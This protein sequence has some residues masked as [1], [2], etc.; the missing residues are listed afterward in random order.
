MNLTTTQILKSILFQ[1]FEKQPSL[2]KHVKVDVA[3]EQ[4]TQDKLSSWQELWCILRRV[5]QD[6]NRLPIYCI[7][8]GLDEC[9]L[10]PREALV[11][12]FRRFHKM[13]TSKACPEH[14]PLMVVGRESQRIGTFDYQIK[15]DE[16]H[17]EQTRQDLELFVTERLKRFS[18]HI[19]D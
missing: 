18:G 11:E 15:L 8:D 9:G 5:I 16:E 6:P 2:T 7:I 3:E 4:R 14:F 13:K 1:L 10:E 19:P 12:V 17:G